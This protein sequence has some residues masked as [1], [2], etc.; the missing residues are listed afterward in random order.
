MPDESVIVQLFAAFECTV[1]L[2]WKGTLWRDTDSF[3]YSALCYIT[4]CCKDMGSVLFCIFL[5]PHSVH[6]IIAPVHL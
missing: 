6:R 1:D 5:C 3:E 2:F 4:S